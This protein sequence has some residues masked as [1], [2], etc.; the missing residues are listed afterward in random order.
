[1]R[2]QIKPAP[3]VIS[4]EID[5]GAALLDSKTNVYFR[6]NGSGRVLWASIQDGSSERRCVEA[7]RDA[8]D[9]PAERAAAD[10]ATYLDELQERGLVTV[11]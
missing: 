6:L 8:F 7:L 10:V 2:E 5:G 3:D 11:G 1:M 4:A 9:I